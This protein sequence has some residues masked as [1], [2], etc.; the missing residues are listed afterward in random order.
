[1]SSLYSRDVF[2]ERLRTTTTRN[3]PRLIEMALRDVDLSVRIA[4]IEVIT[5]ISGTGLLDDEGVEYRPKVARLMFDAEIKVRKAVGEFVRS[6]WEERVKELEAN[7]SGAAVKAKKRAEKAGV[8]DQMEKMPGWKALGEILCEVSESLEAGEES[9][10]S[11]RAEAAVE[12]LWKESGELQKWEDLADY[13]L[14]DH[15]GFETDKWLLAEGEEDFLIQVLI[16][17]VKQ[18]E[19]VRLDMVELIYRTTMK[20]QKR[21]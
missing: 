2:F 19:R 1:M 12:A 14:L 5:L 9:K 10:A 15:S 3:A 18:D 17:C 6:L 20:K 16:A 13:L 7:W 4:C 8:A 21:S 11:G